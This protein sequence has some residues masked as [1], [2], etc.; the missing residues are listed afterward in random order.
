MPFC[1]RKQFE[2]EASQTLQE[3]KKLLKDLHYVW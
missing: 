1:E 3:A 2:K